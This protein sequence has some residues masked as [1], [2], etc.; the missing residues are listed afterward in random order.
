MVSRRNHL[1]HHFSIG[2]IHLHPVPSPVQTKRGGTIQKWGGTKI[3]IKNWFSDFVRLQLCAIFKIR[4]PSFLT[5]FRLRPIIAWKSIYCSDCYQTYNQ[6]FAKKGKPKKFFTQKLPNL[7]P[8]L[9]KLMQLKRV[10]DEQSLWYLVTVD[11]GL[12]AGRCNY[13]AKIQKSFQRIKLLSTFK[14][15][16][17]LQVK[18]KTRSNARILRLNFLSDLAKVA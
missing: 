13:V 11:G 16:P 1:L 6:D 15:P 8:V 4:P 18:P 9:N 14:P 10:T 2:T 12:A 7:A 5:S 3:W 17:L